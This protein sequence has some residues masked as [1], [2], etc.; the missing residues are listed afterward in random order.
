GQDRPQPGRSL[1]IGRPAALVPVPMRPQQ[2]LLDQVGG[3]EQATEPWVELEPGQQ[4]QVAAEPLQIRP[5]RLAGVD[6]GHHRLE[7]KTSRTRRIDRAVEKK[8]M[9]PHHYPR[10]A[11]GHTYK[12]LNS[13]AFSGLRRYPI[14]NPA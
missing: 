4:A 11:N 10:F 9:G 8:S 1:L 5:A 7:V 6:H 14:S 2:G 3:V 12:I 13:F